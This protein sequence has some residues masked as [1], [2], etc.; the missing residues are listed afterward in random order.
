MQYALIEAETV[1]AATAL[2][3]PRQHDS[4]CLGERGIVGSLD[5]AVTARHAKGGFMHKMCR[6]SG[7]KGEEVETNKEC[8]EA[9]MA[10]GGAEVASSV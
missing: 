6:N 2:C 4:R 8:K 1:G 7:D 5:H 9:A 10:E 3:L